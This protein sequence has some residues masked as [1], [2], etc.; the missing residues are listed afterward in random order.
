MSVF[1]GDNERLNHLGV[2]EVAVELVQLIQ[3]EVVPL[4]V[5]RRFRRIKRISPEV[6]E[7]LHQHKRLIQFLLFQGRV[8]G[9][10]PQ[11][12]RPR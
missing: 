10:A 6:A 3:P 9:D 1:A 11:H 4:K 12:P 5:S 7:V 2:D 8:F